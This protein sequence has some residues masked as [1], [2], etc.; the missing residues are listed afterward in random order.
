MSEQ[1]LVA[2]ETAE[3][4]AAL[5][6]TPAEQPVEQQ[7][8]PSSQDRDENGRF[9]PKEKAEEAAQAGLESPSSNGE[10]PSAN[11]P[12]DMV[13]VWRLNEVSQSRRETISQLEQERQARAALERRIQEMERAQTPQQ[14]VQ[15]PDMYQDPEA[16]TQWVKEQA[17]AEAKSEAEALVRKMRIEDSLHDAREGNEETF[18]KAWTALNELMQSGDKSVQLRVVNSR[19]PG[20][21]LLTWYKQNEFL[22]EVQDPEAWRK[23]QEE[24]IR[25]KVLE[26]LGQSPDRPK[27]KI[28]PSLSKATAAA[29][30]GSAVPLNDKELHASIFS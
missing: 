10:S 22:R 5:S 1:E 25:E 12:A 24:A 19:N 26:E 13:P 4:E 28:P 17:K 29:D 16:Y 9:K 30:P 14:P 8:R 3:L 6:D 27:I 2:N 15:A 23:S 20:K 11:R 18:D 7:E 21:E